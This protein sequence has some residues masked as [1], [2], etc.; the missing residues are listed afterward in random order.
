MT[1][2][3]IIVA[4]SSLLTIAVVTI[5]FSSDKHFKAVDN[6]VLL[7]DSIQKMNFQKDSLDSLNQ[8]LESNYKILQCYFDSIRADSSVK[9]EIHK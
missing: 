2:Y 4:F 3:G 1:K 8:E 6:V 9:I 5:V 7:E